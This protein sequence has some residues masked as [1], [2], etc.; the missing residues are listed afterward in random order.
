MDST[1]R[2]NGLA[3][4]FTVTYTPS[5]TVPTTPTCI[6]PTSQSSCG[7]EILE[8]ASGAANVQ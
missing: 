6:S 8:Q 3:L 5:L 1:V 7:P 2:E 4:A